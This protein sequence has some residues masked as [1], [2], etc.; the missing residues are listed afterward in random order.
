MG[1]ESTQPR[2]MIVAGEASA[3]LHGA[4]LVTELLKRQPNAHIFGVGGAAMRAK[5]FEA[6]I[7]AEN[8]S[9]AGLT[10]VLFALPRMFRYMKE[11]VNLAQTRRPSVAV[12]IDL[13][14]FNLR[15]AKRLQSCGI[16]VVY[17]I[18]PQLWAWRQGRVKQIKQ[19][20]DQMLVILP[21]EKDF[22]EKHG[23]KVEF[24]GHPLVEELPE[25]PNPKNARKAMGLPDSS[26]PVVALLP[27]SRRKEVA[28][29]L[30]LMLQSIQLLRE[31]FPNLGVVLP[32]A[33]TIPRSLIESYVRESGV[34]VS[35]QDGSSTDAL[36]A[37][38]AAIVCSGTSTLQTAL[39]GRP[40]VVVYRVSW[41][42]YW[43]LKS[44]VNVAHIAL[45]N[46]I[47]G[48]RLV[49]ELV[50]ARFTPANVRDELKHLLQ[51]TDKRQTLQAELHRLRAQLGQGR[52]ASRVTDILAPYISTSAVKEDSRG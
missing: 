44:L 19:F 41:I 29:H 36:S 37:S 10:E 47:A 4:E 9:L 46:L 30:P 1:T 5:G 8:M 12:L 31:D 7:P 2:V 26:K 3:D 21:F 49:P 15:L 34:E 51:D 42:S 13:P 20:V 14:D 32:I 24:V 16:P 39:L 25:R 18:S 6:L 45:V 23:V 27:G 22:Y 50:Q 43:I 38:D 52:T 33:S 11:L 28:R 40:M 17:Y 35:L 48:K